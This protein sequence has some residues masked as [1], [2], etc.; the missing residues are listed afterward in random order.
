MYFIDR[1]MTNVNTHYCP[2]NI[3]VLILIKE[4]NTVSVEKL[5]VLQVLQIIK[6][7]DNVHFLVLLTY[8]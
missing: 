6:Y 2:L 5:P 4:I 8:I 7:V 3:W 1:V